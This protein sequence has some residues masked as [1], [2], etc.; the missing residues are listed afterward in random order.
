MFDPNQNVIHLINY[1]ER[2]LNFIRSNIKPV[3]E[4]IFSLAKMESELI[5]E[6]TYM[7]FKELYDTIIQASDS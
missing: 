2:E 3:K 5:T 4:M 1:F 7:L 6:S